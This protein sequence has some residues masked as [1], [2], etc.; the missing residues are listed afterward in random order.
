MVYFKRA[1][2]WHRTGYAAAV[3]LDCGSARNVVTVQES[4]T[5]DPTSDF[6]GNMQNPLR[7]VS[8]T[9]ID[10]FCG[11]GGLSYGL[12]N[13]GISI[14]AGIDLDPACEFPLTANIK[15]RFIKAD[16]RELRG[17]DLA[18]SYPSDTIRVLA[19]CAPCRPFSSF[20][21]GTDNTKDDEWSLLN[22][23]DRLARELKPELIT[24][25]NVPGLASKPIFGGFVRRLREYGYYVDWDS[26]Y[27]QVLIFLS[28]LRTVPRARL[29]C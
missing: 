11:A 13:A 28:N 20:R 3:T 25:E 22:E 7:N 4:T 8:V 12:K 15:A 6:S 29:S 27:G 14:V 9:A 21:R 16:I 26:V 2:F 1:E 24:M 19:G 17:K 18:K 5:N 23:F 10:L